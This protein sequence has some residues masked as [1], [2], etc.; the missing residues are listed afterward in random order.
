VVN[1]AIVVLTKI[2]RKFYVGFRIQTQ[3]TRARELW[4]KA[5]MRIIAQIKLE[6]IREYKH[7]KA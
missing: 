2:Y 1:K 4:R 3:E 6:N 5:K 7:R